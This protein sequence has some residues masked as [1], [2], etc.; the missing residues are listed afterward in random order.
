MRS[1]WLNSSDLQ[2]IFYKCLEKQG[3]YLWVGFTNGNLAFYSASCCSQVNATTG[4]N[5]QINLLMSPLDSDM[6]EFLLQLSV[7]GVCQEWLCWLPLVYML[8]I[9]HLWWFS[10]AAVMPTCCLCLFWSGEIDFEM[11]WELGQMLG[12]WKFH[13]CWDQPLVL[14]WK[15]GT[16][17]SLGQFGQDSQWQRI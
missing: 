3:H 1:V 7:M 9:I 17:S 15:K 2:G 12:K 5:E 11:V 10:A 14:I 13:F 16:L 6:A 8:L 4:F